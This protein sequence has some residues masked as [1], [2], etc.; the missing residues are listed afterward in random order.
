MVYDDDGRPH[1]GVQQQVVWFDVSVD[2]A[3]LVDGVD[4]QHR[5][6]DVELSGLFCQSVLLH[7]QGH[8]VSCRTT[9]HTAGCQRHGHNG[10]TLLSDSLHT[11]TLGICL[12]NILIDAF[13]TYRLHYC[14]P[15]LSSCPTTSIQ[16]LVQD[17]AA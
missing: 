11:L 3:Q 2:E 12:K 13:I 14:N 6:S 1:P 15:L 16:N 5:L 8:H 4:G 7:Q 17:A 9:A 10:Q